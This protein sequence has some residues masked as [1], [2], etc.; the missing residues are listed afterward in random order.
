MVVDAAK[1]F[2]EEFNGKGVESFKRNNI[3][4]RAPPFPGSLRRWVAAGLYC[5]VLYCTVLY[6]TVLYCFTVY[7]TFPWFLRS[8][9][10]W[11]ALRLRARHP[12]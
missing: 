1:M 9:R 7:Y 12:P 4:D 8:F 6:C 3:S 2:L 5:T 11:A 10:R